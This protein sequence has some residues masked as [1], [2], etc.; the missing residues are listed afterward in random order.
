MSVETTAAVPG[1]PPLAPPQR[2]RVLFAT[3]AAQSI[4]YY[5]FLIYG[6]AA[7]LALN[8]QFFPSFSPVAAILATFATFAVGFAGR[9]IGAAIFGHIGDKH[10][11]K[12]A[13]LIAIL[14]MAV[15]T[16]LIGLLPTYAMIGVA[17]PVILAV[18]RILQG[19]SIGGQWGGATLLAVEH[20]PPNR[21]AFFGSL[22]QLGV[23]VGLIG[24]TLVFLLVSNL[25]TAEQFAA[26]G[27]RIPFLLTVVMF[28]VAFF[29][30]RYIEESPQ[31]AEVDAKLEARKATAR[32]SSIEVLRRPGKVLLVLAAYLAPS[33]LFYVI[34]TGMIDYGVRDQHIS[35]NTMLLVVM[36]SMVG[37]A[38]GTV[39]CAAL[40]DRIGRRRVYGAGAV[41]GGVWS[42][43][44][45]PLVQ[46]HNF[47]LILLGA[48]VGQFAVGTMFG[49]CT[50]LFAEMF[51]P[52]LR[53]SGASIGTQVANI[54]GGGLAPF[55]M[56]AL[57]AATGTT[58]SVSLYV[59][60]AAVI[61]VIALA[62]IRPSADA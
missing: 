14:L 44:L 59:A 47:W 49:P 7:S 51:P 4:E 40:S 31:F 46:T 21:R 42:F 55:V 45:F 32:S 10:G 9:P 61:A 19:I 11:R 20:A 3:V 35:K 41:L 39:G 38:V 15:A 57:L 52:N 16:V 13:L 29:V 53:Y 36:L 5:D 43:V 27:W 17:A 8:G 34:A 62:L 54:L 2:K 28:P 1:A 56:V 25:T 60:A 26:W 33:I 24:G 12:P 30:H 23:V 48:I 50:A 58:L 18:L 6:T 37:F 22:P